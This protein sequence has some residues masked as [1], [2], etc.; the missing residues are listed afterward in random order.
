MN[1]AT[2]GIRRE[3]N[4]DMVVEHCFKR[5]MRVEGKTVN[6][7]FF[8]ATA[9]QTLSSIEFFLQFYEIM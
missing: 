6:S 5:C 7:L 2:M 3:K 9:K 8:P 4:A 1:A